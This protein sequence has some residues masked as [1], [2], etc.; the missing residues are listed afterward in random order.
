MTDYLADLR[1]S[2]YNNII[3]TI[4]FYD[5]YANVYNFHW[6][7]VWKKIKKDNGKLRFTVTFNS[8]NT[9]NHAYKLDYSDIYTEI[10]NCQD[11]LL[12]NMDIQAIK[13]LSLYIFRKTNIR[14]KIIE[15]RSYCPVIEL[16]Y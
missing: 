8:I 15:L 13:A 9:S 12:V 7:Y 16:Q 14:T 3:N 4:D 2:I 1:E 6:D 5:D 10:S 11:N